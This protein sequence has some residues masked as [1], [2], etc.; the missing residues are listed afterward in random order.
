MGFNSAFKG[1][2]YTVVEGVCEFFTYN[3]RVQRS[4]L[5][6]ICFLAFEYMELYLQPYTFKAWYL[7]TLAML[8]FP[9]F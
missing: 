4:S 8:L 7:K 5:T 6:S 9:P 1:L 3:T 2:I